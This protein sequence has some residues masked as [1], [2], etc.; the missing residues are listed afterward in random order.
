M[1]MSAMSR[2][3]LEQVDVARSD[4]EERD[5]DF[6]RALDRLEASSTLTF[7]S[8]DADCLQSQV[9]VMVPHAYR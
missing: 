3:R 5:K 8:E 1:Q 9:K 7:R 6:T 4:L 2:Q